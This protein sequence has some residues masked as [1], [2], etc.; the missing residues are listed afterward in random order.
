MAAA[1]G[2]TDLSSLPYAKEEITAIVRDDSQEDCTGLITG[3]A[4]IDKKF[5]KTTMKQQL[6]TFSFPLV[7]IASHFNFSSADETQNFLLLGDGTKLTLPE[8]RQ[9]DKLFTNVDM[10]VLSA[11]QTAMGTS[12]GVEID[13]FGE[14][15]QKSGAKC[16]VASLWNVQDQGTKDLMVSFYQNIKAGTYSSKIEALRQAQLQLAGLDDLLQPNG[17]NKR[18]KTKY[19][20]PY[21]WGPF[22]MIGNWR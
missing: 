15:A 9:E 20:S 7:H 19:A 5:T 16:V 17:Q 10:L 3:T 11:C 13:G 8:I 14:L 12:D 6:K 1:K 18:E 2:S 22:I 4:L 21:Y